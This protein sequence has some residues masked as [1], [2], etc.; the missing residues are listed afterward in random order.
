MTVQHVQL[1]STALRSASYDVD[2][3]ELVV[4]FTTGSSYTFSNVPQ[5]IFEGLRDSPSPGQYYHQNIKGRY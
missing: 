5:N 1:Q 3:G 4:G 2:I